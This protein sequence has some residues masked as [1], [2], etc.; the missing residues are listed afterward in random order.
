MT[1]FKDT[2]RFI[3]HLI[4]QNESLHFNFSETP[5]GKEFYWGNNI[6]KTDVLEELTSVLFN[7]DENFHD[8]NEL[9]RGTSREY[10]IEIEK[11]ILVGK[12]NYLWDYSYLESKWD[13]ENLIELIKDEI[14]NTLSKKIG[15]PKDEFTSKYD[16]EIVFSS[17]INTKDDRFILTN[18]KD[19]D[20][21]S[22][23]PSLWSDLKD[24]IIKLSILNASNSKGSDFDYELNHENDYIYERWTEE[25]NFDKLK[26]DKLT[27]KAE[28]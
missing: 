17:D 22:I 19:E 3:K 24:S 10:I 25:V 7:F 5:Y 23:P 28:C 15:L 27:Y 14:Y 1:D 6:M 9:E 26:N 12:I 21:V 13:D 4:N 20:E 16:Y 11:D 8:E 18:W 2:Y